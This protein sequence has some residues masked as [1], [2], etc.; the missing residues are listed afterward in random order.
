M[1]GRR[2]STPSGEGTGAGSAEPA[3]TSELR[4]RRGRAS[5]AES[6]VSST[7]ET[8]S[9]PASKPTSPPTQ[10]KAEAARAE[11]AASWPEVDTSA[12]E[13]FYVETE[14]GRIVSVRARQG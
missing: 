3:I 6:A 8:D 12:H 11:A 10:S 2:R 13:R 14:D 4:Q 1:D 5:R 7:S 9:I